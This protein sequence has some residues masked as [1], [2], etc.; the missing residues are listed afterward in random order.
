MG[1]SLFVA[2]ACFVLSGLLIVVVWIY[3]WLTVKF[4]FDMYFSVPHDGSE[5]MQSQFG[6][7]VVIYFQYSL[8]DILS[9]CAKVHGIYY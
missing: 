7:T 8:Y 3:C 4:W 6:V 1:S 9:V 2:F 5:R